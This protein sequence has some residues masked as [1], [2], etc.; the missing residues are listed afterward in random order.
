[1]EGKRVLRS[2]SLRNV[3]SFGS[4]LQ[5]FDLEPLNVLIGPNGSGKSNLLEIINLLRSLPKDLSPTLRDGGGIREWLWKSAPAGSSIEIE[6]VWDHGEKDNF[7]EHRISIKS[8]GL[9]YKIAEEFVGTRTLDGHVFPNH[10]FN[11]GK[12]A[13]EIIDKIRRRAVK[14]PV[15]FKAD[16]SVFSQFRDMRRYPGL[17]FLEEKFAAIRLYRAWNFGPDSAVRAPQRADAPSD[18]LAEDASNLG[19]ILNSLVIDERV[20]GEIS[21]RLK[22]IYEGANDLRV[23]IVGG[24]VETHLEEDSRRL[25]PAVRLSDGTLRY[26]CLLAILC[27]PEPPPLICIEEPELGLHPD[28]ITNIAE[29]IIGASAKTQLIITTHSDDLVSALGDVPESVVVCEKGTA[30]T[31]LERLNPTRLRR[32]LAKYSLGQIWGMGEIGG[33]RW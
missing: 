21:N 30:G 7:L 6:S 24:Y 29:L 11:N 4:D 1:M 10:F 20:N 27:H 5:T 3:L 22:V 18:F 32:W 19:L 25:I 23:K 28:V 9:S 33:N 15:G 16:N 14:L 2:L 8:D 12:S 26:L 17:A 13:S 31:E